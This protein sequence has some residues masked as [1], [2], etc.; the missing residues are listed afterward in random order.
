[1]PD[2]VFDDRL[3][4]KVG[5][6]CRVCFRFGRDQYIQPIMKSDLLNFEIG[7]RKFQLLA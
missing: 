3:K 4:N 7:A 1:M 2:R 6:L 5:H